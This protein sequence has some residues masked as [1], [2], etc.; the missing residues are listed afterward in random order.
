MIRL[1]DF[2]CI[3]CGTKFET[4]YDD[5]D[6]INCPLCNSEN[7]DR[8]PSVVN[9]AMG[10]AGAYGYYDENLDKYIHTN[11]ERKE[12]MRK[13]GVT[14]KGATPKPYGDAWV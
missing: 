12:E 5:G 13:Q 3:E 10:A 14:E 8:L 2:E 4:L 11:T 1:Y 6:I 9:I 7:V